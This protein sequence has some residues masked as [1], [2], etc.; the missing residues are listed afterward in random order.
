MLL[1]VMG[2]K[3]SIRKDEESEQS[4]GSQHQK[5]EDNGAITLKPNLDI[6]PQSNHQLKMSVEN[7]R[8]IQIF[9]FYTHFLL[10]VSRRCNPS[11]VRQNHK[12]LM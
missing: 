6:Y 5:L 3:E 1:R 9:I 4:R 12:W 2:E 7:K 8:V 11:K 10:K